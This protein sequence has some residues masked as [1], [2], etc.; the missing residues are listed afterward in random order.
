MWFEFLLKAVWTPVLVSASLVL[1]PRRG[2]LANLIAFG[3]HLLI[4]SIYLAD[5]LR[6]R[7]SFTRCPNVLYGVTGLESK[8]A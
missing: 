6:A 3:V 4:V 2:A 5:R 1:V 7:Y 8:R